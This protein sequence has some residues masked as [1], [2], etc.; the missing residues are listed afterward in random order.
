MGANV[1]VL[2]YILQGTIGRL[3]KEESSFLG[4]CFFEE[5]NKVGTVLFFLQAFKHSVNTKTRLHSFGYI[6]MRRETHQQTPS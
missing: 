5:S 2:R 3:K 1:I 6:A 4:S